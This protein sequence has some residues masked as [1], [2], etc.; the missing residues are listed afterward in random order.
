LNI[1][2]SSVLAATSSEAMGHIYA[3]PR[4]VSG[5]SLLP[6]FPHPAQ[7]TPSRYLLSVAYSQ[8]CRKLSSVQALSNPCSLNSPGSILARH[9]RSAKWLQTSVVDS[10]GIQ[11][12]P[13][14]LAFKLF[15][16]PTA[17]SRIFHVS[18]SRFRAPNR[19]RRCG[20][21]GILR[22]ISRD[23]VSEV[24]QFFGYR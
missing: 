4:V 21:S 7:C 10:C 3:R 16:T 1:S 6:S 20:M 19:P 15:C 11:I 13:Q 24:R 12:L 14:H 8:Q 2:F 23:A 18:H 22:A 17:P 5:I 9:P